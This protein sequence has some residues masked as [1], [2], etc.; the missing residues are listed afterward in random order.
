MQKPDRRNPTDRD[1]HDGLGVGMVADFATFCWSQNHLSANQLVDEA[2]L[3]VLPEV[4]EYSQIVTAGR[5]ILSADEG[6]SVGG[7]AF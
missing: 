4:L 2:F 6:E 5:H 3:A 1:H 7:H